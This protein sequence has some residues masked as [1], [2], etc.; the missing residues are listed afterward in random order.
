M[1]PREINKSSIVEYLASM[2]INPA[3]WSFTLPLKREALF[4][5]LCKI[6]K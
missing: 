6:K 3:I 2:G 4:Y 5:D 1:I